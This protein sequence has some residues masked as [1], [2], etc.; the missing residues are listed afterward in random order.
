[1]E[2]MALEGLGFTKGQAVVAH[3]D[4]GGDATPGQSPRVRPLRLAPAKRD[5][6]VAFLRTL[7]DAP[8]PVDRS[9]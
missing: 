5:A 9:F 4:R 7:D 3:Y 1:M 6:L 2:T 8:A